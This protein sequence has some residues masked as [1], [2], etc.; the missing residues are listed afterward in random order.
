MRGLFDLLNNV[1]D[2]PKYLTLGEMCYQYVADLTDMQNQ[3]NAAPVAKA[4]KSRVGTARAA[5]GASRTALGKALAD[6]RA[7]RQLI[8]G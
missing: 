6:A 1:R 4:L 5:V 2:T 7:A 3:L 8:R